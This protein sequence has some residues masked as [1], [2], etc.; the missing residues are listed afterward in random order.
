M[1]QIP[2]H[3]LLPVFGA[4]AD[5]TRVALFEHLIA[6]DEHTVSDLAQL[7]DLSTPT[8][9]RHLKVLRAAGLIESRVDRQWRICRAKPDAMVQLQCWLTENNWFWA[10]APSEVSTRG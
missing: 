6:M 10:G 3:P 8:I 1:A 2:P 9:S 4:L 5:P 7:F